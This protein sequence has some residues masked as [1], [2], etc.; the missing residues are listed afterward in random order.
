[1]YINRVFENINDLTKPPQVGPSDKKKM[2]NKTQRPPLANR[3][4]SMAFITCQKCRLIV[5]LNS[6]FHSGLIYGS[7]IVFS[8]YHLYLQSIIKGL[9]KNSHYF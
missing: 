4:L 2:Q 9:E 3:N 1:M 6:L 8:N 7:I 5:K